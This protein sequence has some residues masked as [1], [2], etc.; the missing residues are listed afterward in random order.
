ME[1]LVLARGR[2]AW[3]PLGRTGGQSGLE[4]GGGRGGRPARA[5][6]GEG[7]HNTSSLLPRNSWLR[8]P[9]GYLWAGALNSHQSLNPNPSLPMTN[10]GLGRWPEGASRASRPPS[11]AVVPRHL[12]DPRR[13]PSRPS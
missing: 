8:A 7:R 11:H 10:R 1:G 3:Q 4:N 12:G 2:R 9:A 6:V 13:C 5:E